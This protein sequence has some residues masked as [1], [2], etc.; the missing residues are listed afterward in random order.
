MYT[1]V[2]FLLYLPFLMRKKTWRPLI[3]L[4]PWD[5]PLPQLHPSSKASPKDFGIGNK[6]L[7]PYTVLISKSY[8]TSLA[9]RTYPEATQISVPARTSSG[10]RHFFRVSTS[11]GQQECQRQGFYKRDRAP[12]TP[13][14]VRTSGTGW[15]TCP[16]D[17]SQLPTWNP[18]HLD[19]SR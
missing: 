3:C 10:T 4:K 16:R 11:P 8:H 13:A 7:H 5:T 12:N 15:D 1:T 17:D 14:P 19:P 9:P 6:K 18:K 2:C